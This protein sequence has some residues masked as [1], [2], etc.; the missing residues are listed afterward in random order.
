ML[1]SIKVQERILLI[2]GVLALWLGLSLFYLR[3]T[4]TNM[5][6][7]GVALAIA[8]LLAAAALVLGGIVDWFAAWN[9]GMKHLH[10]LAFYLLAGLAF[11]LTG[12]FLGIYSEVSMRRL[13]FFAAIH[14]L[15]FGV[16][17]L[18]FTSR[19]GRHQLERTVTYLCGAVS[20]VF[21]GAMTAL[22]RQLDE[23]AATTV[24]AAYFCFVGVKL[25][26]LSW[27]SYRMVQTTERASAG[28][29]QSGQPIEHPA[30]Q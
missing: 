9:E 2:H 23:P 11:A 27:I 6:F 19:A 17:A 30:M 8:I 29:H 12:V 16:L 20:I 25:L 14:A 7:E 5:I 21:S 18:A 13:V 4:M 28:R 1:K 10:R 22:A 15:V 3:A 24:L 26:L